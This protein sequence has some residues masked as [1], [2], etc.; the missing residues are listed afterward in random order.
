[1]TQKVKQ[2]N[3]VNPENGEVALI[4]TLVDLKKFTIRATIPTVQYGNIQPEYEVEAPT[5]EEAEAIALPYIEKLWAKYCGKGNELPVKK[6]EK[7]V[8]KTGDA[9]SLIKM[10]SAMI[11]DSV[12]FDQ[13]THTYYN[14]KKEVL[15]S[16]SKFAKKFARPFDKEK[17]LP[18]MEEKYGVP[19]DQVEKLW[20][21]KGGVSTGFGTAL[22]AALEMYGKY[23]D[24][25]EVL[26]ANKKP[27]VNTALHDHPLIRKIV[28]EFYASRD[29]EKALY[30]E[31]VVDL[32][33]GLCGQ[34]DRVLIVDKKKKV[35][36]V[37]D[38]KFNADINKKGF[39]SKLLAPFD[40][41]ADTPLNQYWIQLSFY[42]DILKAKGWKVEAMD[43]FAYDTKW[44]TYTKEPMDLSKVI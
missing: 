43:I 22:H 7:P 3:L 30:E 39:N 21:L 25:G 5:F 23:K 40:K 28:E 24:I 36:R 37:Q 9:D 38:F 20:A 17:I 31:F 44:T 35:C 16:G 26:G 33:R 19:A 14:D 2:Q 29:K 42:A 1:M 27:S 34:L 13:D 18:E 41:I 4:N 32:E 15:L 8:K 11:G 10:T 6:I 12:L